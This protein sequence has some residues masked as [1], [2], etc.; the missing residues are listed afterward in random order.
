MAT[1][2]FDSWHDWNT[3]I[4]ELPLL[5][6]SVSLKRLGA[7][8][9]FARRFH[10]NQR[11]PAGEPYMEHLLEVLEILVLG[12]GIHDEDVL[13]SAILHDVVEDTDCTIDEV[14][15]EFGPRVAGLVAWVTKPEP[16]PGEDP[17][18]VRLRYLRSIRSAP[19]E[20]V[21]LKL[22]D[23]YSNVQRLSTHPRPEKQRSY[24][25]ETCESIVPLSAGIPW[26]EEA[27]RSWRNSHQYLE[28]PAV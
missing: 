11:R 20:V 10:G 26:F 27:F 23:R 13:V 25:S 12:A 24:Y 19:G 15:E 8:V 4:Q 6:P 7:A 18:E 22:A 5:A 2:I 21:S 14:R 16:A 3:G 9:E 1:R 28:S 17:G